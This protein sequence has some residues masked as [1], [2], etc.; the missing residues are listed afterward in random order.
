LPGAIDLVCFDGHVESAKLEKLWGFYWN[1]NYA[2][3]AQR[4]P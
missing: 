1:F 2:P 4:P 3:P